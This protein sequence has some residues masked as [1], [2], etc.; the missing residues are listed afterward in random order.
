MLLLLD[1]LLVWA[2]VQVPIPIQ[3][4]LR[5]TLT[6]KAHHHHRRQQASLRRHRSLNLPPTHPHDP[7][8]IKPRWKEDVCTSIIEYMFSFFQLQG[9]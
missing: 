8:H 5:Q 3:I 4:L 1:L 6:L 7:L 2:Q 9:Y